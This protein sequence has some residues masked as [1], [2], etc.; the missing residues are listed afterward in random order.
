MIQRL[1]QYIPSILLHVFAHVDT[2]SSLQMGSHLLSYSEQSAVTFLVRKAQ[3]DNSRWYR[4]QYRGHGLNW[5]RGYLGNCGPSCLD[6]IFSCVL[7]YR[8][9]WKPP[10]LMTSG[11]T[12][13]HVYASSRERRR[14]SG[15]FLSLFFGKR[16][17]PVMRLC[18]T[19][20]TPLG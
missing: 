20:E 11:S 1:S 10:C 3:V 15:C 19:R 8:H 4:W 5:L 2:G 6:V 18:Q 14:G 7:L 16:L 12:L 9:V 13:L 17:F